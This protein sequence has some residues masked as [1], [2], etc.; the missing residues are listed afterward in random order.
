MFVKLGAMF[1]R[2]RSEIWVGIFAAV[3]NGFLLLGNEDNETDKDVE[4]PSESL[5]EDMQEEE[6]P[7]ESE[8]VADKMECCKRYL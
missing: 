1:G 6:E 3:S 7:N 5:N 8:M 4:N 2:N